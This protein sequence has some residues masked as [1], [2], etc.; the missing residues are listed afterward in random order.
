MAKRLREF[1]VGQL[2]VDFGNIYHLVDSS[3]VLGYIHKSD[4]LL[5]PFEGV[6]VSEV[7]TADKFKDGRL[8]NWFWIEGESNPADWATKPHSVQELTEGGFWQVGPLFLREDFD[9]WPIKQDFKTEGLDGVLQ[10]KVHMTF[11]VN[12]LGDQDFTNLL[13]RCSSSSKV[14]G[15][16]ADYR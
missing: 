7:Q 2:D 11:V 9:K 16:V 1:I 5:K 4:S 14:F 15:F 6:R 10:H 12:N 13:E 3:T 8:K